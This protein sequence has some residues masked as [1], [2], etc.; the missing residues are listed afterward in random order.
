MPNAFIEFSDHSGANKNMHSAVRLRD[1]ASLGDF[2]IK[3]YWCLLHS[4]VSQLYVYIYLLYFAFPFHLGHHR[5]L[6]CLCYT[7]GSQWSS[8]SIPTFQF[9]P[10]SSSPWYPYVYSLCLCLYFCFAN[11]F[12]WTIFLEST[13]IIQY[14]FFSFWLT[15]LCDSL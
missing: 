14:F 7:T 9:I 8:M 5:A 13:Y 11:K 1:S 6:S 15:S 10:P 3:F 2:K 4:K 12:I